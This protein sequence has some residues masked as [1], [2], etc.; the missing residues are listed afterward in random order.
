MLTAWSLHDL[1]SPCKVAY[2]KWRISCLVPIV[3]FTA[4]GGKGMFG[5]Q[6]VVGIGIG[7]KSAIERRVWDPQWV[8][9]VLSIYL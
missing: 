4:G 5:L 1:W 7:T 8:H 3:I 2:V 9:M 6:S